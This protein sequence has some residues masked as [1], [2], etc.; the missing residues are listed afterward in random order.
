M[1]KRKRTKLLALK[2]ALVL[3][4]SQ[5]LLIRHLLISIRF[6]GLSKGIFCTYS[7]IISYDCDS[8]LNYDCDSRLN[9]DCDSRLNYDC[10]SRLNYDCDSRL[11]YDCD[12][13]L[14]YDCESRLNLSQE[15]LGLC[16]IYSEL[17]LELLLV[18]LSVATPGSKVT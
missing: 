2:V 14:N 8:R 12:S 11:N 5:K 4:L 1:L 15:R 3:V 9:Y 13:R 6:S 18:K 7:F 10:D 16:V 17:S